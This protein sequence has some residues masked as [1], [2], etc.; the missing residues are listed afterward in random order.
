MTSIVTLTM[1]PA[2][3]VNSETDQVVANRKLRC[4]SPSRGPGGGGINVAR[5]VRRLGGEARAVFMAG[6]S[7]GARLTVL[8]AEEGVE[9]HPIEI[10]GETREV[11][12]IT[13][14]TSGSQFR[15]VMAG[16]TLSDH[17]WKAALETIRTLDPAPR[18]LVASGTL[19]PGVPEDF[20][21]QVSRLAAERGIALIVDS[22]GPPLRHA[23]GPAT[24]LIKPNLAELRELTGNSDAFSDLFLEGAAASLVAAGRTRAVVI[25]LGAGGAIVATER[26][27]R[28]IA[29]PIVDVASRVGAGDSMLAGIV[30]SLERGMSI[31]DAA[32]FGVAA[33]AAAV[34]TPGTQLC[35][36]EDAERLFEEMTRRA[37]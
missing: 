4:A 11:V 33:G 25:S 13:E 35:R 20:Y 36:R 34:M 8:V 17:E 2:L 24:L 28:R 27:T 9:S 26:G 1:N 18:Y 6:G 29:A 31:E 30:L 37:V 5:A 32:L 14:R 3:D 10:A 23:V 15:F 7:T 22:S 16:P 19:P 21:A 12:N